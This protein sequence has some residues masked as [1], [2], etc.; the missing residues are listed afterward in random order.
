MTGK[1]RSGDDLVR[2]A[3]EFAVQAH[4]RIVHLRKYTSAPYAVHL[5]HV[6]LLVAAATDDPVTLAAA[7]LHDVVEDTPTT[8]E[9]L[10]REFGRPVAELVESLTDVS[11]PADGNRA[12]RKGKDLQHLAQASPTAKTIKLAD[13]VDNCRDICRHDRK[14]ARVYL[15]EMK[16]LLPV[17]R[18]GDRRLYGRAEAVHEECSRSLEQGSPQEA[19]AA[20]QEISPDE[21]IPPHLVRLF[22]E[23]FTVLDVSHPVRSF[24]VE[25]PAA[26][27]RRIMDDQSLEVAC[28]REQGVITGYVQRGDLGTGSCGGQLRRFRSGQTVPG[29]G[30]LSVLVRALT[31]HEYAF[32]TVLGEVAGVAGRASLNAPVARMWLFGIVTMTEMLMTRLINEHFPG[33]AWRTL[34]SEGRLEKAAALQRERM[35]RGQH[36]R[37]LECLQLSDKGQI[38][39]ERPALIEALGFPSKR[40]A[41][42]II[43]EVESLRNNLAHSQDVATHDWAAI[44]RLASRIEEAAGRDGP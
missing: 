15:A 21:R 1:E 12:A 44:A 23:A 3:K 18:E 19:D 41:K 38:L 37:L 5:E 32:V 11:R 4:T 34:L 9:D 43:R 27:V 6:A 22:R 31:V 2:R 33:G 39:I 7:W 24:G 10:E 29:D 26:D 25:Q 42:G 28:L 20:P 36:S 14:F 30:G 13:L 40:A 16:D 17:L 35:R 8:L